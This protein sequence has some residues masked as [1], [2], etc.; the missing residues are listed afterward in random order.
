MPG[1]KSI[2]PRKGSTE[3]VFVAYI[4]FLCRFPEKPVQHPAQIPERRETSLLKVAETL[5]G[6]RRIPAFARTFLV[7][8][9]CKMFFGKGGI[10]WE[11]SL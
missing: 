9:T 1:E 6:F 3:P 2:W 7:R 11:E 10:A 8:P 4:L 5:S